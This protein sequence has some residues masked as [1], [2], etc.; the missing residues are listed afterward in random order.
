MMSFKIFLDNHLALFEKFYLENELFL[1]DSFEYSKE[2]FFFKGKHNKDI[3]SVL[4]DQKFTDPV[5][6]EIFADHDFKKRPELPK[7]E[8]DD[9]DLKFVF[10]DKKFFSRKKELPYNVCLDF[11]L[12]D[13]IRI[14]DPNF[15]FKHFKLGSLIRILSSKL[16][17]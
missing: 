17:S 13:K 8:S 7:L 5:Y 4:K 11:N 10:K 12:E 2:D 9:I 15:K 1:A 3:I 16:K 14:K 6:S